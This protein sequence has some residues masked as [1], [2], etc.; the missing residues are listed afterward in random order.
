M[1]LA[2]KVRFHSSSVPIRHRVGTATGGCVVGVGAGGRVVG[3][4]AGGRVVGVGA[5]GVPPPVLLC[6][7]STTRKSSKKAS[8]TRT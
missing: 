2:T 6:L 3:V 7:P 1:S 8:F 4:G 5:G